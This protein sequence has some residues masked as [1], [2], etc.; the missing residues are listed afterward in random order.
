RDLLTCPACSHGAVVMDMSAI[1]GA[2]LQQAGTRSAQRR[3]S[4]DFAAALA[5]AQTA[6]MP[7]S[8]AAPSLRL[9]KLI[10]PTRDNVQQLASAL[11]QAMSARFSA[12]GI[13]PV[14][15]VTFTVDRAGGIQVS[16]NRAD[17]A[18]IKSLV[19]SDSELQRSIRATNAVASHAYEI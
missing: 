9:T 7:Q 18:A 8:G 16:G 10:L 15:A 1:A 13:P 4:T 6:T 5:T 19:A 3:A 14:P 12:A 2:S 17:L 11:S